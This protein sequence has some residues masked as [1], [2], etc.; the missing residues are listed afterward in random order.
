[1]SYC[2]LNGFFQLRCKLPTKQI[3]NYIM[4]YS[5]FDQLAVFGKALVVNVKRRPTYVI[6]QRARSLFTTS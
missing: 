3:L 4:R 6:H 2:T 5:L 1:M